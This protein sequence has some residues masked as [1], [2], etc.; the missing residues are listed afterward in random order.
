M[1]S[2]D[3]PA[4]EASWEAYGWSGEEKFRCKALWD[5]GRPT[6]KRGSKRREERKRKRRMRGQALP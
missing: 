3:W 6:E 5:R 1:L 2:P 4:P